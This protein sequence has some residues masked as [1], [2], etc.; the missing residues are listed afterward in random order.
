M[1]ALHDPVEDG[2]GDGLVADPR[3]PVIN[4]Q[5]RGDDGGFVRRAVVDDL[6]QVRP[7]GRVK[8]RDTPIIKNQHFGL[9]QLDQPPAEGAA[10]VQNLE[11]S[12]HAWHAQVKC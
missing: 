12:C 11:F 3:M 8:C 10:A 9:G 7:G 6:E 5:L 1:N 2:I 4:W